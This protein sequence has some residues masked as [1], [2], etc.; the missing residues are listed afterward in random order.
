VLLAAAIC[1]ALAPNAAVL[2]ATLAAMPAVAATPKAWINLRRS[3][4][5]RSNAPR[6]I[7]LLFSIAHLCVFPSL[8][9]AKVK[10]TQAEACATK[11]GAWPEHAIVFC[12]DCLFGILYCQGMTLLAAASV[13]FK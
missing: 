1:A 4:C 8:R 10:I 12:R 3:I 5:P 13:W 7:G 11:T 9:N 6:L 2:G